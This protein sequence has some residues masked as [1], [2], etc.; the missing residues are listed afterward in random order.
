MHLDIFTCLTHNS[1]PYAQRLR[2]N[3]LAL[4]S[5]LHTLRFWALAAERDA[6][7][8]GFPEGWRTVFVRTDKMKPDI[9]Q[10]SINHSKLLNS[11]INHIP[12]D[13]DVV[14]ISDCDMYVVKK[15]WD[16]EICNRLFW[17]EKACIGTPKHDQSLRMFFT[18]FREDK[19][20]ILNPNFRPGQGKSYERG[21]VTTKD[22]RRVVADTGW[23][24]EDE[25]RAKG[26]RYEVM[27][28]Q[29]QLHQPIPYLFL[30]GGEPFVA[31][32]GGSHKKEFTS[33]SVQNWYIACETLI[34][35]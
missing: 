12:E 6:D 16:V 24:L 22:G 33:E 28:S 18:A 20:R 14:I 35:K 17:G 3:L 27:E 8:I 23:R 15:W 9:L 32:M 30:I 13:S 2:E 34:N 19:Y 10:P 11:L 29:Q 1:V 5:G 31:H 25:L 26:M 4:Q 7:V 21:W